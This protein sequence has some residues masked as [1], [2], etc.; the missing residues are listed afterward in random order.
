MGLFFELICVILVLRNIT[1]LCYVGIAESMAIRKS[2]FLA[3]ENVGER[4]HQDFQ[5]EDPRLVLL[6]VEIEL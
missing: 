2:E 6:V 1:A 4:L 5:V 3:E